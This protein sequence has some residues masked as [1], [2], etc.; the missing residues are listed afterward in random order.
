MDFTIDISVGATRPF[1]MGRMDGILYLE[2]GFQLPFIEL[3]EKD[4]HPFYNYR[5]KS[6]S[7]KFG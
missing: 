1:N 3:G 4:Q 6:S 2:E 7:I 5:S